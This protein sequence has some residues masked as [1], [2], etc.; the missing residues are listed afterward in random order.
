M[1]T[2]W[3][4]KAAPTTG[5]CLVPTAGLTVY[6]APERESGQQPSPP[7]SGSELLR[8]A[9]GQELTPIVPSHRVFTVRSHRLGSPG[10]HLDIE[11]AKMLVKLSRRQVFALSSPKRHE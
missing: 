3:R 7:A 6:P 4:Q 11:R 2:M 8:V 9:R 10:E 5:L 1:R